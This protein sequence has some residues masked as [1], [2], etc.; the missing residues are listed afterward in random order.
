MKYFL[1]VF[2]IIFFSYNIALAGD[3]KVS[4]FAENC[5]KLSDEEPVAKSRLRAQDQALFSA[6]ASLPVLEIPKKEFNQFD[7]NNLIYNLSDNYVQDLV[8]KTSK[9]TKEK[10]CVSISGYLIGSDIISAVIEAK[11]SSDKRAK[12]KPS[13]EEIKKQFIEQEIAEV[14]SKKKEET[15]NTSNKTEFYKPEM[16]NETFKNPIN[17][18]EV[19]K[20][21]DETIKDIEENTGYNAKDYTNLENQMGSIKTIEKNL[22]TEVEIKDGST[23]VVNYELPDTDEDET[24]FYNDNK[25]QI[26]ISST[27]FYND[28]T[29]NQYSKMLEK[30][31]EDNRLLKI[32]NDKNSAKY[33]LQPNILRVKVDPINNQ[34]NRMQ[35]VVMIELEDIKNKSTSKEYQNRFTVFAGEDN[36]Q[37][38]AK[39][40][41]Q[42]LLQKANSVILKK[43]ENIEKKEQNTPTLPSVITPTNF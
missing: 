28:Q 35:M 21:D 15:Y 8:T 11:T 19:Y 17:K 27:K 31:Y 37:E 25:A 39:D 43:I 40:L 41:M 18:I 23:I 9:Q 3:E 16:E 24:E 2:T 10:I 20:P 14:F 36:E 4:I 1:Y 34:T 26:F 30:E 32:T 38:I 6:V 7:Y 22:N 5:S 13:Q 42:S 12:D 33:I 29:S